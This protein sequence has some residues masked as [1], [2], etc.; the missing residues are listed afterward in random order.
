[1]ANVNKTP[2][3]V[4]V[5]PA[6]NVQLTQ[7]VNKKMSKSNKK[8]LLISTFFIIFAGLFIKFLFQV[9]EIKP[10]PEKTSIHLPS[11]TPTPVF[12]QEFQ[13]EIHDFPGIVISKGQDYLIVQPLEKENLPYSEY[14]ISV[15]PETVIEMIVL[16]RKDATIQLK[17]RERINFSDI[18]ENTFL[19]LKVF[20]N[21][22]TQP[23]LRA[24][25]IIIMISE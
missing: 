2:L 1:M 22:L 25:E 20:E 3:F 6:K 11:L 23:E 12:E 24:K 17:K 9:K 18:E 19:N 16:T 21:A 5:Q 8:I 4:L 14:K 15:S 10:K 7:I 13:K